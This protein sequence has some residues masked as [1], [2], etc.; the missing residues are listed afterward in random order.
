MYS[1]PQGTQLTIF[2]CS[3]GAGFILG[4]LYDVIRT[5]R[6]TFTSSRAAIII[7]D[8]VYFV[9]CGIL[10]FL[11]IL[12]MNKGEVRFYIIAGEIIGWFFYYLSLGVAAIRITD[13]FVR[14]FNK[15][16]ALII[17]LVCAPFRLIYRVCKPI[18]AKIIHLF[19]KTEKKSRQI[20]KKHLP[21]LRLYVYNLFG[22]ISTRNVFRKKGGQGFGKGKSKKGKETD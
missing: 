15:T 17:R 14:A 9:L 13:L 20:R 12:A 8:V 2:L 19:K 3:L 11:F 7:F 18:Y 10:S 4:V 1:V 22:I 16:K 6:L 21:K 5:L